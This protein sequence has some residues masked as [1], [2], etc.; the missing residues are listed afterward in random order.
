MSNLTKRLLTALVGIPIVGGLTYLG[1]WWFA[2]LVV[3]LV[4]GAQKEFYDMVGLKG[5]HLFIG[6]MLGIVVVL[7]LEIQRQFEWMLLL[8]LIGLITYDTFDGKSTDNWQ[9][10]SWMVAGL[11][12][13]AW[14]FSFALHLRSYVISSDSYLGFLLIVGLL[15]IVWVTDSLAYFTGKA[16]GKR[17]LAPA[18]SPKKTWEGSLGGF[19]GALVAAI[20]FKL[21]LFSLFSWQDAIACAIIGGIGGQVGDLVESRLKRL[22]GVKDSGNVLP[23]H[24]GVLD[25]IDGLILIMPLYYF[26][27]KYWGSF[28]LYDFYN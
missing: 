15:L 27:F 26:Y 11:V 22:F 17:P 16:F 25:R 4:L 6:L 13:P 19:A 5:R 8:S 2:G 14:M 21:F 23:G 3:V 7:R 10:L 24:G 1:S 20:L 28:S 9:K 12:Y 18:I